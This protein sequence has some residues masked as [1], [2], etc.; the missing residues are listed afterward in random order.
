MNTWDGL[1]KD[2]SSTSDAHAFLKDFFTREGE[3]LDV[4]T[5]VKVLEHFPEYAGLIML[6]PDDIRRHAAS[7]GIS[8]YS[9]KAI[10]DLMSSGFFD[11][12]SSD[13]IKK[14]TRRL[15]FN[16]TVLMPVFARLII[17]GDLDPEESIKMARHKLKLLEAVCD[18][19]ASVKVLRKILKG[20]SE[21][22]V[23]IPGA[24]SILSEKLAEDDFKNVSKGFKK[25]LN[26][27]TKLLL[28]AR[29]LN[30][31]YSHDLARDLFSNDYEVARSAIEALSVQSLSSVLDDPDFSDAEKNYIIGKLDAAS[32]EN[33]MEDG[34]AE[35]VYRCLTGLSDWP[36]G[37]LTS[38]QI[39]VL[40]ELG[41][42]GDDEHIRQVFLHSIKNGELELQ[43]DNI[44]N[45]TNQVL[46]SDIIKMVN[47]L[48]SEEG[49]QSFL[50]KA[51][52]DALLEAQKE[53]MPDD[54]YLLV[55]N[56]SDWSKLNSK[57]QVRLVEYAVEVIPERFSA[58]KT[59]GSV[60]I[61]FKE[62]KVVAHVNED[63]SLTMIDSLSGVS[64]EV[65]SFLA[66]VAN[67]GPELPD[68]IPG[69]YH[70]KTSEF[71]P[72]D[73]DIPMERLTMV[74]DFDKV[75]LQG[76]SK[77]SENVV[78]KGLHAK[79]KGASGSIIYKLTL[80]LDEIFKTIA[81]STEIVE[82]ARKLHRKIKQIKKD[83]ENLLDSMSNIEEGEDRK[84]GIELEIASQIPRHEL[85]RKLGRGTK[86]QDDNSSAEGWDNWTVK[87][88]Q[89]VG[90]E[91]SVFG[92]GSRR[93][94][95]QDQINEKILEEGGFSAELVSPVLHGREGIENLRRVM[96]RLNR[97]IK[98]DKIS[99][100][101]GHNA[102]T[103]LHVHH[104]IQD[105]IKKV[106]EIEK[107]SE[108]ALTMG[109]YLMS[110][111][112][113]LYALCSK[114]RLS[115]TYSRPL[116][117]PEEL[118]GDYRHGFAISSY[119]TIEYRLKEATFNV[120]A[121]IRWVILTQKI[122]ISLIEMANNEVEE[123]KKQLKEALDGGIEMIVAQEFE[124]AGGSQDLLSH[125]AYYQA[126]T[127]FAMSAA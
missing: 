51:T 63:Q 26:E 30:S 76:L 89:S 46:Y 7:I 117:S 109:R 79:R 38:P 91:Y 58:K 78:I 124:E 87:F 32:I 83:T 18:E 36:T 116:N 64:Q 27:E 98:K 123:A 112:G 59:F 67:V 15:S 5:V 101:V 24:I 12:L 23:I 31:K 57:E 6:L 120:E 66:R 37:V 40:N 72:D 90:G 73:K 94:M 29:S 61:H 19:N 42:D 39:K 102:N 86:A 127:D 53:P 97:I 16:E 77:I 104:S 21:E 28:S 50:P 93:N 85:A 96:I 55:L 88:D 10:T 100:E 33:L 34:S 2:I 60:N 69:S 84:F 62:K 106:G 54:F 44:L 121:M 65:K 113:A 11:S 111:Q 1:L 81:Q 45:L 108:I 48:I 70:L 75:T 118:K 9:T 49:A 107:G 103:G 105:L 92:D 82:R 22:T 126:A 4:H 125:L 114:W 68:K 95:S 35:T 43:A 20:L 71:I 17:D 41:T 52:I 115:S 13:I 3:Y 8:G 56:F 119:G 99:L 47:D 14:L 122:T 74:V 80:Q 25:S 110:V